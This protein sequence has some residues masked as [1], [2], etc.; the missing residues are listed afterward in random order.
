[1]ICPGCHA[2]ADQ[3]NSF[4]PACGTPLRST[5]GVREARKTVAILFM[6]LVGSTALAEKLDPEPLRQIMDRYFASSSACISDHGGAIEKFI[7]DAI[8][9][10][11]GAT[12][13]HEDDAA[14][15]VRAAAA[16]L[17]QLSELSAGLTRTHNVSLEARCGIC[18]GEVMAITNPDGSFRVI[19]D[20][21]NTA[22]RLQTAAQP[23]GILVDE[24]TASLVRTQIRLEPVQALQLKGKARPVPA[25]RVRGLLEP[26]GHGALPADTAPL[27]GR[28]DELD[29]LRQVFRRV[30]R[31]RQV[32]LVTMLG[33]P[34]IG[35]SRLAREFVSGLPAG[36]VLVLTGRCSPYGRGVTYKPLTEILGSYPGGWPAVTR[37]FGSHPA[38]QAGQDAG[39]PAGAHSEDAAEP[40]RRAERY[41]AS[42]M[43]DGPAEPG[44]KVSTEEISWAIRY[45]LTTL[46]RDRCVVL[47][48]EDLQWAET[49]LLDLIDDVATWLTDAPVLMLCVSRNELIEARP[50]WGGGKLGATTLEL[51]PLS[52]PQSAE[53]VG[54]LALPAD[55]HAHQQTALAERVAQQ[56]EGNPLFAELMLDVYADAGP[57]SDTA[58]GRPVPPTISALLTARLDQLSAAERQLIEI[59]SVIGRDFG[60]IS[61][62][63][64]T[65][66]DGLD[67]RTADELVTRLIRRRI[68]QRAG[69]GAYRFGQ[70]LLRDTAY[71]LSP[72]ARREHWHL[73]LADWLLA[74]AGPGESRPADGRP[75][76]GEPGPADELAVAYHVEAACL[77]GRD[78]R[79]G[80]PGAPELAVL[81]ARTL[82][83]AGMKA[84]GRKD[85]P[86]AA[87]LLERGRNLLPA[88]DPGQTRLALLCSDAWLGLSDPDRALAA[89]QASPE[90]FLAHPG[91]EIVCQIQRCIVAVRLGSAS[92]QQV[93]ADAAAISARLAASPSDDRAWC[94][95]FQLQAYLE[96][97]GER[98]GRADAQLRLAR[99]RAAALRDSYEEE[100]IL[101][102]ICELSQ[103][104]PTPVRA[105]LALCA[106]MSARFAANRALLVPV[107]LT[108]AR[109]SALADELPAAREALAAVAAQTS[110]LHL[111]LA[112]AATVAMS[113]LVAALAG[114]HAAAEADYRRSQDMLVALGQTAAARTCEACAAREIFEQ[115]DLGRASRAVDK[116][117]ADPAATAASDLRTRIIIQALAARI[118]SA[119]GDHDQAVQ[120]AMTAAASSDDTDD[121]CLQGDASLDLAVVARRAGRAG[122][123]DAAAAAALERYR[124]RG[125]IRLVAR[126]EL[127]LSRRGDQW[128]GEGRR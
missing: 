97:A 95:L 123:A 56:C 13:S 45:L 43:L 105:G 24:A 101:G 87:Q 116:L 122:Q 14:R 119:R 5:G 41:L 12:V 126:A 118:L 72:K 91:H 21:V 44:D 42:I 127:W 52:Y 79:P 31:R 15:A 50:D 32:C 39:D 107:L 77:L 62:Q 80:D 7:G 28:D 73:F 34:G 71:A 49:T 8:L 86:G 36:D 35:K 100:R 27:V 61:L 99:Q 108:R 93:A 26:A 128:P 114:E 18:C 11:F 88:G 106:S 104:T 96:L 121:L 33:P 83:A 1:M 110:E 58:A 85:L 125:A 92:S 38:G 40:A 64:L 102:A 109:L 74:S 17:A 70:A 112:D 84:L 53:L 69:P 47:V 115:G 4:C 9:A 22:S 89:V 76:D 113:G 98:T 54:A 55:V 82:I 120:L 25:W 124:A 67:A 111:D 19:G 23:G 30:T 3:G 20:P 90:I 48:W 37:H 75:A 46:G 66:A 16:A 2:P 78:L 63:A 10:V 57:A 6:D 65:S 59:A 51:G 29:D 94:R 117:T 68:V 60:W 81:A 103:W